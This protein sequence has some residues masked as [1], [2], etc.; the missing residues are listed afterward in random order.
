VGEEA[1]LDWKTKSEDPNAV[2]S[3]YMAHLG[4]FAPSAEDV[5]KSFPVYVGYVALARYLAFYE[6][7][8]KVLDLPGHIAEIGTFHGA[9]LVFFGKLIKLFEPHNYT[10]AHG[11][12]WFQGMKLTSEEME[13]KV[14]SWVGDYERLKQLVAHQQLEDCVVVHKMDVTKDLSA[15][16]EDHPY[17]RFKLVFIDCGVHDVITTSLECLWPRLMTG[18]ILMMD[19]YNTAVSPFESE[20]V[21]R[22]IGDRPVQ[23]LAFARQPTG[24]VVK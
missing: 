8:K 4:D 11:F 3:D 6:L 20:L 22:C 12:D 17:M 18:G 16:L 1:L 13:S 10:Q 2:F 14:G 5:I 9:S 15:F 19:H 7:Y 24:Y 21:D 23:K